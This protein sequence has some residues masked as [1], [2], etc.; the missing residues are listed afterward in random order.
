[1]CL[2]KVAKGDVPRDVFTARGHPN[3]SATNR[4]TLE[5]TKDPYV[6]KRG[7]CIV[8]CCA[9]KAAGELD[10]QVLH[11]LAHEGTV[12]VIL[13]VGT[14]VDYVVG[15]TP[16]RTPTSRWRL[17]VRKSEYVDESTVAVASDKS[18]AELDRRLVAEL[19]RGALLRVIV[20][21]CPKNI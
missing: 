5:I 9:E 3:I 6:T 11:A 17:V 7:D 10:A 1:M 18:A 19:K 2:E 8:A 4:R 13:D 16:R 14:A 12:V 15:K 21:V 20:G